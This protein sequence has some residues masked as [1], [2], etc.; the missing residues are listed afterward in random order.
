MR[1]QLQYIAVPSA[2]LVV[3]GLLVSPVSRAY[4]LGLLALSCAWIAFGMSYVTASAVGGR[5]SAQ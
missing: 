3:G 4:A 1:R 2:A 5:P